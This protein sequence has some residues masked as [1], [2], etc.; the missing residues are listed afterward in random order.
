MGTFYPEGLPTTDLLRRALIAV[1]GN[2]PAHADTILKYMIPDVD[3]RALMLQELRPVPALTLLRC[4]AGA[5]EPIADF[6]GGVLRERELRNVREFAE[7]LE[8]MDTSN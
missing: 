3:Q 8:R 4:Q 7:V 5:L 1:A 2:T 6:L